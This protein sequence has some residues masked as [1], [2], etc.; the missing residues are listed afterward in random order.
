MR[1]R[2][3]AGVLNRSSETARVTGGPQYLNS[4]VDRGILRASSIEEEEA[5][6]EE[7]T[8][9]NFNGCV[10]RTQWRGTDYPLNDASVGGANSSWWQGAEHCS[11]KQLAAVRPQ[12]IR[13]TKDKEALRK[14]LGGAGSAVV[15]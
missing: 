4:N 10:A 12:I 1:E 6:E 3:A 7:E 13:F 8:E 15:A 9:G 14:R 11:S 5:E 2:E